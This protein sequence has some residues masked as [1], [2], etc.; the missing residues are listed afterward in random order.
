[1]LA[2][3]PYVILASVVAM[4]LQREN[5]FHE[6]CL[7]TAF[8]FLLINSIGTLIIVERICHLDNFPLYLS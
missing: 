1:M 5:Q 6:R 8:G 2:L 4:A 3:I 7:P